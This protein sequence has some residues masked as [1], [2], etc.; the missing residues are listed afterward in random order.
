[1]YEEQNR[2][3]FWD[4]GREVSSEIS[5]ITALSAAGNRKNTSW[6]K[7]RSYFKYC[8]N[9]VVKNANLWLVSWGTLMMTLPA[10]PSGTSHTLLDVRNCVP[11]SVSTARW[12]FRIF[13]HL[14]ADSHGPPEAPISDSRSSSWLL[15]N[16]LK[17]DYSLI[18]IIQIWSNNSSSI[19]IRPHPISM[20]SSILQPLF[21][22]EIMNQEADLF[23]YSGGW[24]WGGVLNISF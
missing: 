20:F 11:A 10:A 6:L 23:C 7:I 12:H 5:Q 24:R 16:P 18:T 14:L 2:S 4:P 17:L 13:S 15:R 1:M 9:P 3:K 21:C 22:F 19:W 8:R